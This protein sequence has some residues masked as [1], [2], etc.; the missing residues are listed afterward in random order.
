MNI[1]TAASSAGLLASLCLLGACAVAPA[2]GSTNG[3]DDRADTTE[4]T[5]AA[6]EAVVAA[7]NPCSW[8]EMDA[9]QSACDNAHGWVGR[10]YVGCTITSCVATSTTIYYSYTTAL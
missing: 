9:A 1:K 6:S 2:D 7:P 3:G 8:A 4:K 5:G 10:T